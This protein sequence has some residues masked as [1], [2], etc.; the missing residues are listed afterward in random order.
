MNKYFTLLLLV[1]LYIYTQPAHAQQERKKVGVVLSGGG[2][3]GVAHISA[4]KVIEEAG[5]PIDLVVGTSMGA[6]VGGLYS[7]GFTTEQLDSLVKVQDWI[8]L[9]SDTPNRNKQSLIKREMAEQYVLSIPFNKKPKDIISGGVIKGRNLA[10]LFSDLTEGYHDSIDF[11]QLPTPFACV[12]YNIANGDEFVFH[13][14]I[15]ATAMRSSMS[16]PGAFTPIH[17]NGMV[18]VDGGM[19]NNYPVDIAKKMGAEVIIG[20]DVQD[21]LKN[22][23]DLH[24]LSEVIGQIVNLICENKYHEN[25]DNSDVHI[26]VDISNYSSTS[27]SP[28]AL[29][30][31]L[32]R[33]E[34]AAR[35]QWENLIELKENKIGIPTEYIPPHR[36]ERIITMNDSTKIVD[37]INP[38]NRPDNMLNLGVRFDTETLSS[39]IFN[40]HVFLDQK[41][42]SLVDFTV[43]LGAIGYGKLDYSLL[44]NKKKELKAVLS[45]QF[46]YNDLYL[47]NKGKRIGNYT[48][49]YHN[50]QAYIIR[51]WHDIRFAA[52]IK[53]EYFYYKDMLIHPQQAVGLNKEEE[54]F[55][56]YFGHMQ[57]ENY[58][59]RVYPTKGMKWNVGFNLY[60]TNF[61]GYYEDSP[62]PIADFSWESAFS[63]GSRFTILPSIYGR[64]IWGDNR[65]YSIYNMI[66]GD[67]FGRFTF[68]QMPFMGIGYMEMSDPSTIIGGIKFRQ[69]MGSNQY[70]TFTSNLALCSEKPKD[71]FS[72]KT[73]VGCGLTYGYNTIVG[74]LEGTFHWSDRT[75]SLG[76]LINLGYIF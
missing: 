12:A 66:G 42:K 38:G 16:V 6:I 52:G 24:S 1:I 18:L 57:F 30:S 71:I 40:A 26:K 13:N 47:Y 5:I 35:E 56:S 45:Y 49:T 46:N 31:L 65:P 70:L 50:P 59:K 7:V 37:E 33:G 15:L 19:I 76:F 48:Y 17:L 22:A 54:H 4:L 11:N 8:S 32:Q 55:V 2:A 21:T 43:R 67:S 39:I 64:V 28:S 53:Y 61:W 58:N 25:V 72:E 51:G 27:F 34:I 62:I 44:L 14:G 20:V 63:Y 9:L 23:E 60:T 68:Q 69:R 73:I 3:K 29:D 10:K 41:K 36:E 74:P 75:S